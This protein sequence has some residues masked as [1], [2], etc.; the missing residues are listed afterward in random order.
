MLDQ[1][2]PVSRVFQALGEPMR[3]TMVDRLSRGS[4]SV[5]ELAEPFEM[6]LAAILQHVQVLE[7]SGLI[8]T[9]KVGR[10]RT[11]TLAPGGLLEAERWI[12]KRRALWENR[13]DRLGTFLDEEAAP[14]AVRKTKSRK[15][16]AQ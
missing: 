7:A 15:G 8:T 14:R 16:N 3:R 4:M 10:V 6:T 2:D 5:S 9:A 1:L 13:L 11:C 12:S